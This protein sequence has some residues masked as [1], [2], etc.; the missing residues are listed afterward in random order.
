V[1][2]LTQTH[3]GFTEHADLTPDGTRVV[4]QSESNLTGQ[5]PDHGGEIYRIEADGSGLTQVSSNATGG[6]DYPSIAADRTTIAFSSTGNPLGTNADGS[7]EICWIQADGTGLKQLTS[8]SGS[9]TAPVIA[10]GGS[11]IAFL[12]NGNLTSG[13]SDGSTEVFVINTDGTGLK[14]LTSTTLPGK[15]CQ[16][17]RIDDS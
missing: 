3:F 16:N 1:H 14:Q 7:S 8:S 6:A 4:F 11:K 15:R 2:R 5:D 9:S 12:S 10:R 17:V 13:N